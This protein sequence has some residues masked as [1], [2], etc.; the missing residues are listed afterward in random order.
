MTMSSHPPAPSAGVSDPALMQM[1]VHSLPSG[2]APA[3]V[4]RTRRGRLKMMLVLAVCAAPVIASYLTYYVIRPEGRVNHGQLIQPPQPMPADAQLPLRDAQGQAVLASS[5]RGQWL[6][7]SVAGGNCD[8]ACERRLYLQ[9]QIRE[10][11]GKERHRVDRIWLIHD[12]QPM[13]GALQQAMTGA[14]VLSVPAERLS[15]WLQP[16]AGQT[17]ASHW[18]VVDPLGNWM[19]R[20]SAD[21]QPREVMQDLNRLLR[22]SAFW[23]EAGR[24]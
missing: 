1:S 7:I 22:A 23:D 11:L 6:F 19:M 10:A 3:D 16:E 14:T 21:A 9:R 15:Q 17:L 8:A 2:G 24:P 4:Q 13:R 12:G 20:F 18:Y 5:L